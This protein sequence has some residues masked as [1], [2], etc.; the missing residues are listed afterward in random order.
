MSLCASRYA[1]AYLRAGLP[2]SS[3]ALSAQ[4]GAAP[5]QGA[6]H[7]AGAAACGT[8][9]RCARVVRLLL[10]CASNDARAPAQLGALTWVS[11][12]RQPRACRIGC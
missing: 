2:R 8:L 11:A 3:G 4:R 12:P 10:S 7:L 1:A 6:V 5:G 9:R